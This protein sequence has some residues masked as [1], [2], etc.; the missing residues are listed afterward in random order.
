MLSS[1]LVK[2]TMVGLKNFGPFKSI[3]RQNGLIALSLKRVAQLPMINSNIKH[4]KRPILTTVGAILAGSLF[5]FGSSMM[6]ESETLHAILTEADR[7]YDLMD[8]EALYKFL[9]GY[10]VLGNDDILWRLGRATYER[11]KAAK[12]DAEK[13][14][15][16]KEALVYVEE[17]LAIN[18][19]NFAVHK[20]MS[21]LIDYVYA[22]DGN[23]AR[24]SQAFI[25]KKHM[26]KACEL[27]P[28]DGTSWHLLGLWFYNI[29]DI[30][31]YTRKV[32]SVVFASPPEGTFQEALDMFLKGEE[33]EPN[34]YSSNLLYIGK[35]YLK[36]G[37]KEEAIEYL[38][39]ALNYE[40]KSQDD[41]DSHVQAMELLKGLGIN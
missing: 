14:V 39:R 6:A 37:K 5:G 15:L 30:P 28:T 20:W 10:R 8:Y 41:R 31:W 32:A 4:T 33:V 29:A 16:Y 2:R 17:A 11:A 1:A 3:F 19:N 25:C 9:H 24:I 34:F 36:I 7:L 21:I 12:I 13:K 40:Q 38:K 22:Y 26:I 27:N 18:P 35:C 23:K